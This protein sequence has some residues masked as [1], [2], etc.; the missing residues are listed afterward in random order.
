MGYQFSGSALRIGVAPNAPISISEVGGDA[1]CGQ[2][3]VG[4]P[5]GKGARQGLLNVQV[6]RQL[7]SDFT[8]DGNPDAGIKVISRNFAANVAGQG[9]ERAIDIQ[10]RNSGT[11]L[12]LVSGANINVRNDVGKTCVSLSGVDIRVED[13]GTITTEAVGLNVN[14]SVENSTGSP[15]TYGIRVRNTDGSAQAA[16]K[17]VIQVSNTSTNG[18]DNFLVLDAADATTCVAAGGSGDITFSNAWLKIKVLIAGNP[19][20]LVASA[21]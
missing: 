1:Q 16:I 8:W 21:F 12:S 19:Y 4:S 10:A 3:W 5:S 15:G 13:Y 20:Y 11:F 6:T 18:F 9:A 17:G 7:G 2:Q 14:M